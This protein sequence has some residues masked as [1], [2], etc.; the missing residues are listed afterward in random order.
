MECII[1]HECQY[2]NP[3]SPK[4]NINDGIEISDR[5]IQKVCYWLKKANEKR[6]KNYEK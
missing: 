4:C 2:Y 3:K 6:G 5:F 1:S